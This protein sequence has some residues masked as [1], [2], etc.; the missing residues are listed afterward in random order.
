MNT[1]RLSL[2]YL[3]GKVHCPFHV[4]KRVTDEEAHQDALQLA[5]LEKLQEVRRDGDVAQWETPLGLFWFPVNNRPRELA[6]ILAEQQRGVYGTV[7]LGEVVIDCGANIGAFTRAAL[8]AGAERVVAIEPAPENLE[9]LKRTFAQEIASGRLTLVPK[10]VWDEETVL[11]LH[12][13][14]EASGHNSMV[15]NLG[16]GRQVQVPVTTIDAVVGGLHI[17]PTLV[18]ID[19]EGA[20][21]RVIRGGRKTIGEFKPR[22]AIATEHFPQNAKQAVRVLRGVGAYSIRSGP[23]TYMEGHVFP[24]VVYADPVAS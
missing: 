20:E 21:D 2:M 10:G 19:T 23:A 9:C 12:I 22:L 6:F 18:K 7:K 16:K 13:D 14:P 17:R 1:L 11:T 15:K 4:A 5:F 8:Q 24:E 3:L